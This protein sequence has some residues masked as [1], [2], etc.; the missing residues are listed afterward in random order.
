MLLLILLVAVVAGLIRLN[1][2][3]PILAAPLSVAA[4]AG[5]LLGAGRA[6]A[7][8]GGVPTMVDVVP[9]FGVMRDQQKWVALTMLAYAVACG[10]TAEGLVVVL[11]RPV[12]TRDPAGRCWGAARDRRRLRSGG[13]VAAVGIGRGGTASHFPHGWYAADKMMGDGT[14]AVL[15]LPWHEYQPFN[16]TGSRT[17]ATPAGAFFRRPVISSDAVES[18]A[19]RTTSRSRRT[20]YVQRLVAA[21]GTGHF[22]RLV[23]PLGVRYIV[24]SRDRETAE[25]ALA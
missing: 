20:A 21:G 7:A 11:Q 9:L 12:R 10:V 13:P 8:S 6:G 4:T 22:G 3:D 2:Q 23:A 1:R 25:Y 19:V 15:F 16:F 14:E 24:L 5:L 17:V 18:G